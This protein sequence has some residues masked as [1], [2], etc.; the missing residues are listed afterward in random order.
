MA[1]GK[2]IV[3]TPPISELL[4]IDANVLRTLGKTADEIACMGLREFAELS[5][6]KGIRWNVSADGGRIPGLTITLGSDDQQHVA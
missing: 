3:S 1:T 2:R 6:A 5:Y 4:S